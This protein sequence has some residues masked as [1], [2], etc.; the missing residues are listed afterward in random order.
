M[1]ASVRCMPTPSVPTLSEVIAAGSVIVSWA[2]AGAET[3]VAEAV[4]VVEPFLIPVMLNDGEAS[5]PAGTTTLVGEVDAS[6]GSVTA[7]SMRR[8]PGGAASDNSRLRVVH[9]EFIG[10]EIVPPGTKL[11]VMVLTNSGAEV[12]V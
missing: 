9:D 5:W 8:S 4:S 11:M 3:P 7:R 2:L 1:L 12:A 10:A 6:V